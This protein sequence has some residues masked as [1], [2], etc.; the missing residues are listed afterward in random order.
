MNFDDYQKF[1][2]STAVFPDHGTG[3]SM[4]LAYLGLGL[5]GEFQEWSEAPGDIK[6]LGDII[7]YVALICVFYN[8]DMTYLWHGQRHCQHKPNLAEALKKAI[9]DNK[10]ASKVVEDYI[11]WVFARIFTYLISIGKNYDEVT[12]LV[13]EAMQVNHD[14]LS[15]RQER[16]VLKGDGNDR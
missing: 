3:S 11:I 1:A 16:G 9:R 4:E 6:E 5:M 10:D 7:W 15:S 2:P 12:E 13:H 8:W 14:K